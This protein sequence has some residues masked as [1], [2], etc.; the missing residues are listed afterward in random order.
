VSRI[1]VIG[2]GINGVMTA[3]ALARDGQAVTLFERGEPIG[4]TSSRSSKLLHGGLRYLE[5]GDF[6]LVRE[7][8]R[9]RAWW[10]SAAPDLA[11]PLE[12]L[13][14]IYHGAPRGKLTVR[15]GLIAYDLLAGRQRLGWHRWM[16]ARQLSRA[17]PALRSERLRGAFAYQDGQMD[18]LALGRWALQQAQAA[19]AA[20]RSRTPV[21]KLDVD[22]G[23]HLESGRERFDVVVNAAG[24]WA[25]RLLERSGID[26]AY[27]LDL[28][29]GSH[30][31]IERETRHGY[32][33]QSPDDARVC[34]VL[35]YQ[36]RTLI[37]TTEVR[38][39]LDEPIAC[40]AAEEQYLVRLFNAYLQPALKPLEIVER[41]AGIRPLIAEPEERPDAVS[42]EYALETIGRLLNVFGGKWTTARSLGM[43]VAQRVRTV[44]Q[45]AARAV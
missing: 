26:S 43:K 12:I 23:V 9:E 13:L 25:Y 19:G 27:R 41:F 11:R 22:G 21:Q 29:R 14:P 40:S 38:Q 34:F 32:L 39:T 15:A 35:P 4:E 8:L 45:A 17:A 6:A 33:L 42:R 7:G 24:P 30:L 1:A 36:G 2:A 28:V 44:S 18:D 10:L 37:G 5:H 20:V 16:S 31:L 3:W